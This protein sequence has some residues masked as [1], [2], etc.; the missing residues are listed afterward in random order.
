M[1]QFAV[2]KVND[3]LST[4]TSPI[5]EEM[6]VATTFEVGS[7]PS[8]TVK[9]SVVPASVTIVEPLVS[10]IVRLH[11]SSSTTVT[12]T[13]ESGIESKASSLV[14]SRTDRT[15]ATGVSPSAL[16]SFAAVTVI[17]FGVFSYLR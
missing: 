3:A 2:V 10:V 12:F 9:V 14:A 8:F 7:D 16:V 17:V 13:V 1:F 11:E 15:T 4:V 6:T 5:S